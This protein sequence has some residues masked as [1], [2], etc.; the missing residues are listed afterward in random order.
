MPQGGVVSIVAGNEAAP[1]ADSKM[2]PGPCVRLSIVDNGSGMD[3]A[4]LSRATDPFFT[5]KGV[6][7]GTGLGLSMVLGLAQQS[8]GH[9][10]LRSV[11]G[12]GATAE[13]WLPIADPS[14]GDAAAPAARPDEPAAACPLTVLVV[15]DDPLV[16]TNTAAMLE[17]MGHVV[18]TADSAGDALVVLRDRPDIDILLTDQAMPNMSGV[19]LIEEVGRAHPGLGVILATGYTDLKSSIPQG[20]S[21]L[22]KPFGLEALATALADSVKNQRRR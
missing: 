12:Q 17:T 2:A 15:D 4:T 5:T 10:T 9:F 3:A 20:I 7:K 13:L 21:R 22:G 8:G 16:L 19:E 18:H 1:P 6:G 14:T 11:P